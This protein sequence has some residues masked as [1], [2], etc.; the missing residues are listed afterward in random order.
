[1]CHC[2]RRK[3]S[4]TEDICQVLF[5]FMLNRGFRNYSM[6]LPESD[7]ISENENVSEKLWSI[8]YKPYMKILFQE[9]TEE[10]WKWTIKAQFRMRRNTKSNLRIQGSR[11]IKADPLSWAL[12]RDALQGFPMALLFSQLYLL[13]K[14][15]WLP[16]QMSKSPEFVLKVNS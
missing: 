3:I 2:K 10:I 12:P 8:S 15:L 5:S 6:N 16:I 4:I 13:Q 7:S 14:I 1:M 9:N 11:W